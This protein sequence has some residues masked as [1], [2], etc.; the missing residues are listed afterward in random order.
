MGNKP[1]PLSKI[2]KEFLVSLGNGFLKGMVLKL[3]K[4]KIKEL[5]GTKDFA[6]YITGQK[7][8]DKTLIIYCNEPWKSELHARRYQI[9]QKINERLEREYLTEVKLL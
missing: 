3:Y 1:Q 9:K 2:G 6:G 8:R 5:V 4:A 7:I